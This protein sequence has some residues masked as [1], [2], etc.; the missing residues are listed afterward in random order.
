MA[1]KYRIVETSKGNFVIEERYWYLFI[2][3][4]ERAISLSFNSA[5][6]AEKY[7]DELMQPIDFKKRTVK[8]FTK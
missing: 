4:W 2:P 5:E 1:R 3:V 6:T 7:F 8:Y